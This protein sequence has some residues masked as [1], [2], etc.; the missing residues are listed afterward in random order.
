MAAAPAAHSSDL[1]SSDISRRNPQDEYELIQKIGSGTYGDVYKVIW[2]SFAYSVTCDKPKAKQKANSIRTK[3]GWHTECILVNLLGTLHMY[4]WMVAR[5]CGAIYSIWM[6]EN[7]SGTV[8]ANYMN[9]Y[10]HCIFAPYSDVTNIPVT[11][12]SIPSIRKTSIHFPWKF[13]SNHTGRPEKTNRNTPIRQLIVASHQCSKLY[14]H[15]LVM[16]FLP[17][18][19][20][21]FFSQF[22]NA[23]VMSGL[24]GSSGNLP[25]INKYN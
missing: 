25:V 20:C 12:T 5:V 8:R 7:A 16:R 14:I 17:F 9:Y 13:I 18:Q 6:K 3:T 21:S 2:F 22:K 10:L 11:I 15:L 4:I 23:W 1:L 19:K 24:V